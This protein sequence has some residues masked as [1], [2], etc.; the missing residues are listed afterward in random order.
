MAAETGLDGLPD[1]LQ[2]LETGAALRGV[3]PDALGS[4]VVD[5][6]ENAGGPS[7]VGPVSE[8]GERAKT[9]VRRLLT[10]MGAEG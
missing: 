4:A 10:R 6:Q 7:C 3:Q 9:V 1:R 8:V 2:R 5:S